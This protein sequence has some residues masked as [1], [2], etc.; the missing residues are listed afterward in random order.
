MNYRTR[1]ANLFKEVSNDF[2][3]SRAIKRLLNGDLRVEHYASILTEIFH[4]TRED[5]QIQ[6]EAAV[7]FHGSQRAM[8]GPFLKH[9][10]SEVGHDQL[11]LRDLKALGFDVSTTPR[12][13]PLPSTVSL[14]AFTY[15]AIRHLDPLTYLGYL[16]FLEFAP[17]QHGEAY[18]QALAKLGVP[19]SA[20]TFLKE[21]QEVDVGHNRLMD[22]Y[23]DSLI[24]TESH[25]AH[26]AYALQVTGK[27][28]A[29]MLEGAIDQ[30]DNPRDFGMSPMETSN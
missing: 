29:L 24:K 25:Y 13:H 6:A 26:V 5:P 17:T 14:V 15:F 21:H 10:I 23:V 7:H 22:L 18:A 8:V 3:Q 11:A 1:L 2:N 28:Y 20:M 27:L 9:A 4:Y 19:P 16:Y 30:V 12:R